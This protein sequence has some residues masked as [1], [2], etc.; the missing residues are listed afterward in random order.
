[1]PPESEHEG[2][3]ADVSSNSPQKPLGP[4]EVVRRARFGKKGL[5]NQQKRTG[6]GRD[7][8]SN[9]P[10]PQ[11]GDLGNATAVGTM[12]SGF[13]VRAARAARASR[14]LCSRRSP[15]RGVRELNDFVIIG[16]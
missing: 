15:L 5:A 11:A 13:A 8:T 12:Q 6:R 14:A 9:S 4:E 2:R 1:M 7:V 3:V 16:V 10:R